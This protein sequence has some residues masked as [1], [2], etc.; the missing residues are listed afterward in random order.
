MY[1]LSTGTVSFALTLR[2]MLSAVYATG[3]KEADMSKPQVGIAS[4]WWEG[5]PCNM[6]LNDLVSSVP[7]VSR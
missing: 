1:A 3:L 7:F 2:G 5:N 6:H 4:V